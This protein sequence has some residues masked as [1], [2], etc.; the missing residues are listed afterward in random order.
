MREQADRV[1]TGVTPDGEIAPAGR[2]SRFRSPQA[3][4]EA[5]GRART[6]LEAD[7]ANGTV[8]TYPDPVTGDPTYVN[9]ANGQ[10]VRQPVNV[11]TNDPR[12]FGESAQVGRRVGGPSSPYVLDANGQRIPDLVV[13]PQPNAIVV[14]EYVPSAGEWRPVTYFP[15]P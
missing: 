2:A 13:G 5:L 3:E 14:W 7:L 6:A 15:Q 1:R 9:P 11:T 12:G 10:P 4:A 8:P